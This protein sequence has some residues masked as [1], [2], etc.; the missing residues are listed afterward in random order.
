MAYAT[1]NDNKIKL[2]DPAS[3]NE[4]PKCTLVTREPCE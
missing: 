1:D 3:I 2:N 4:T